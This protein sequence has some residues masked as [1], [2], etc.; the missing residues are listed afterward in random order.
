MRTPRL[1][2]PARFGVLLAG[3]AL[4][5]CS[6]DEVVVSR[7]SPD[8]VA[9]TAPDSLAAG[10]PLD[11]K[12]HWRA[13]RTCQSLDDFGFSVVNDSTLQIIAVGK[14]T[15]DP[16]QPCF[17]T[18]AVVEAGYRIP[19]PPARRFRLEVFGA[20]QRFELTVQGGT[21]PADVQRFRVRVENAT[22]PG[23]S[24]AAVAGAPIRI[25]ALDAPDTLLAMTTGADG[26]ADS[27][28][29]CSTGPR[30]YRLWVVGSA[31]RQVVLEFRR[32]PARCGVPERTHT[33]F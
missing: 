25:L 8:L 7:F 13:T 26:M 29:T 20:R 33:R 9:V 4:S 14:E 1:A 3:L 31:G 10:Q 5:G 6:S 17:E 22:V 23:D 28:L 24:A 18:S 16:D 12:I 21:Q 30:G 11:V 32:N 15:L 2:S 27:A 19:D